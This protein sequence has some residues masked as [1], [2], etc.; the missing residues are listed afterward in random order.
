MHALMLRRTLAGERVYDVDRGL[1]YLAQRG[2]ADLSR[3]GIMGLSGGGAISIYAAALLPRITFAMPACCFCT[4]RD[5]IMSLYHCQDN[6]LPGLLRHAEMADVLGLFAPKPVVV[7]AGSQDP[8]F[9]LRATEKAFRDLRRIYRACGAEAQCRLVVGE[10]G[11]R[12]YAADA[13]PVL[14]KLL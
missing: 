2:D 14:A 12:F 1:D 5:S 8:L 11:H 7:V 3:T 9:P 6:Y 10:G 4:F 13:W